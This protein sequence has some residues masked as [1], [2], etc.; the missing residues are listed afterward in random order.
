MPDDIQIRRM[1][2]DDEAWTCADMMCSTEPWITLGSTRLTTYRNVSNPQAETYV[3]LAGD[4]II[5]VVILAM[6]VPLIKGYINALAVKPAWRN[7]GVGGKLLAHAEQ[8][9]FRD[10]PNCFLCVSSF[11]GDAQRFYRRMGYEQ[12]GELK[13]F[14]IAGASELLMRKTKG[15]WQ[16]FSIK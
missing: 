8:R 2:G 14:V 1:S 5:G 16:T 4:E 12:V 11:N 7:R 10:S 15:P 9:A 13:D 6:A 3:A